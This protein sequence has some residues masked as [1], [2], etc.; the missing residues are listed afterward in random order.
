MRA[1]DSGAMAFTT[2]DG[3]DGNKIGNFSTAP[4]RSSKRRWRVTGRQLRLRVSGEFL[5]RSEVD[6]GPSAKRQERMA[7]G[8]KIG[9][10]WSIRSLNGVG[11]AS[12]FEVPAN[13]L[14]AAMIGRPRSAPNGPT[15]RFRHHV[16]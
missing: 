4:T 15:L 16:V 12:G 5:E 6:S 14:R 13:H 10:L 11:D 1:D 3:S 7:K 8:V 2:C 9:V